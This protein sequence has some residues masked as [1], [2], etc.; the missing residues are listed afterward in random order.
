M[1]AI[2]PSVSA[3]KFSRSALV[4]GQVALSMT[5]LLSAG[6]LLR[7]FFKVMS[8]DPGFRTSQVY[9]F[10]IGIP[11]ARYNTEP[12]MVAFHQQLLRKLHEMPGVEPRRLREACL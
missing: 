7:S 11:E 6:L 10:G 4:V 3:G 5:L 8:I 12:K 2:T 1:L 9:E